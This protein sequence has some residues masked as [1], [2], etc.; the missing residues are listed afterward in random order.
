MNGG[1]RNRG[2][3]RGILALQQTGAS[4]IMTQLQS[5]DLCVR[6]L[7]LGA[8]GDPPMRISRCQC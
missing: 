5:K 4:E 3:G 8:E 6:I 1:D 2:R 7:G